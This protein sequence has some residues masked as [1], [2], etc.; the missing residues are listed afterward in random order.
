MRSV[1]FDNP[2]L[3]L[4]A[5][6]LILLTVIPF[7]IAIRKENRQKS[8]VISLVLHI[9]M[10]TLVTLAAAGAMITTILTKTTVYVVADVS[11]SSERELDLIDEYIDDLEDNL[12]KNA[13][14]GVVCFAKGE[15]VILYKP[16]EEERSV[17]EAVLN[18]EAT[19]IVGALEYTSNLFED[20]VIKKIV[21]ITDGKSTDTASRGKLIATMESLEQ[22]KI[23]LDAI[24]VDSNISDEEK[25]IQISDAERVDRTYVGVEGEAKVLLQSN[26]EGGAVVTLK[27]KAPGS[28][29]YVA[30]PYKVESVTYGYN[31]ITLPLLADLAGTYDYMVEVEGENDICLE[32]NTLYFSQEV[33]ASLDLLVVSSNQADIDALETYYKDK[34]T[35]NS[36][37]VAPGKPV[38]DLPYTVEQLSKYDEIIISNLD[39]RNL[40]NV[41]SFLSSLEIV[42]SQ[43]GK[44]LTT[45]GDLSIQNKDDGTL[46]ALSDML[47]L[48]YGNSNADPKV[49]T[50]VLD[51]SHSMNQAFKFRATKDSAKSLLSLLSD[52]DVVCVIAFSQDSRVIQSPVRLGDKRNEINELI[53]NLEPSQGTFLGESL[54]L[55]YNAIKDY[56]ASEKQVMLISDG[57]TN[58]NDVDAREIAKLMKI[59]NIVVSTINVACQD[60]API[61]LLADIAKITKGKSYFLASPE[62]A[63]DFI[64]AEVADDVTES[65]IEADTP[66]HIEEIHDK[67]LLGKKTDV[68]DILYVPNIQGYVQTKSKVDATV[69]LSVDYVKDSATVRVPLYSY[70]E[71]GNGKVATFTT[72]PS[73]KWLS[74]W[75][76]SFK[77]QFFGNM[78]NSHLPSTKISYPLDIKT[79][80]DGAYF[81]LEV[82]PVSV[83]IDGKATLTVT[84]PSGQVLEAVELP[85]DS[86]KFNYSIRAEETGKY[87]F[88][89]NYSYDE[90]KEGINAEVAR[91]VSYYP[92]YDMFVTFTPSPL[93]SFVDGQVV[94]GKGLEIENNREDL[95]IYE[96]SFKIP[97]LI[98]AMVIFVAD[99]AIRVLR[100]KKK[101]KVRGAR[102]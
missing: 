36:V 14:L 100:F 58:G 15:P 101:S 53:E 61:N 63:G 74:S 97:F 20:D 96:Y 29:E 8:A 89:V 66:V 90:N 71:Y 30:Q 38:K 79:S 86:Q 42:V 33:D 98:A 34:A 102:K 77:A 65:I 67:L 32:N 12:P 69:V 7:I 91:T 72:S 47:P 26:Y 84:L 18:K 93:H 22:K 92:E 35:I 78:L 75:D 57:K 76:D 87:S 80:F 3:L 39:I 83:R 70:R 62:E 43:L 5:I 68:D 10:V 82:A 11:Y 94:N 73:G 21:L 49:Y 17:K 54:K 16:G 46:G 28:D 88:L 48:N 37:Y 19:D 59:Y 23:S 56:K 27:V 64:F 41:T 95:A 60:E 50:L 85:F 40:P 25:E 2:W 52:E 6:P 99:V 31:M 1:N 13:S 81:R 4:L 55:A 24:F 51:T 45:M 9:C 44:T